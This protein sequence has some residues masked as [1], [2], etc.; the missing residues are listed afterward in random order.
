MAGMRLTCAC[1]DG[2]DASYLPFPFLPPTHMHAHAHIHAHT[3]TR[4][5][6]RT[7]ARALAHTHTH[8]YTHARARARTHAHAHAHT[9]SRTPAYTR[10]H[11]WHTCTHHHHFPRCRAVTTPSLLLRSLL[12]TTSRPRLRKARR[13]K[14]PRWRPSQRH[15]PVLPLFIVYIY[16][17]SICSISTSSDQRYFGTH[18]IFFVFFD[19][20][21]EIGYLKNLFY[22]FFLF[23]NQFKFKMLPIQTECVVYTWYLKLPHKTENVASS[24]E[25]S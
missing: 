11:T 10:P 9:H 1:V 22:R 24:G 6:T 3:H 18:L 4:A 13:R 25:K 20:F 15:L 8:T 12:P 21:G 16:I 7:H 2:W 23:L 5:H 17:Q 14:Q 19:S